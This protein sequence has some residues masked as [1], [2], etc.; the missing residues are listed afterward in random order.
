MR[1][2]S[3]EFMLLSKEEKKNIMDQYRDETANPELFYGKYRKWLDGFQDPPS[4]PETYAWNLFV[5]DNLGLVK[6]ERKI[7]KGHQEGGVNFLM[8]VYQFN[9]EYACKWFDLDASG[10]F[11][12]VRKKYNLPLAFEGF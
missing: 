8:N 2:S 6:F 7:T 3:H 5:S 10:E 9:L 11:D 1:M 4:K 12:K